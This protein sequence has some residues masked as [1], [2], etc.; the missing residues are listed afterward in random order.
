MQ[1]TDFLTPIDLEKQEDLSI[2]RLASMRAGYKLGDSP[3]PTANFIDLMNWT[4]ASFKVALKD[5]QNLNKF[6][7]NRIIIDGQFLQFCEESKITVDCLYKDSVISW[8]TDHGFEKF[9]VQGVFLIKSKDMEFLHAAL[10]HKGNQNE[11]EI[12][13]FVIVSEHNYKAYVNLRN[14]FDEWVQQR[15]RSNLHIRVIEGEDMPYTKDH[16]WADLFLPKEIKDQLQALVE[17]FLDSKEFYLK[18]RIPWKRGILLYG[19]PGN[20]KTSII[21]TVMS[22]YNFKPVTIVPGANDD[23]VREAF[24]YAEEQSPSLLYFED[25]DSLLEKSVDISSFLNLM[26]GISTKNG[27]LVI[28]TANDVKKLKSNITDRPSRFDRKF[29]IP[30]PNQEMAYI[31]L[32]RWFGNLLSTK[33]CKELSRY[34][35]KYDFSYAYLK[36]LYIS[37]MFEALSHNRKAPTEKDIENALNRLVKDKNI[38]NNG[39]TINTDKYFK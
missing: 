4:E 17:N 21:R 2:T 26:D 39:K 14:S 34:A 15:D 11:D 38:L 16:T 6:V 10:F 3:R 33:K 22:Q 19:K 20:G 18:N 8:K 5:Q 31:Y 27:L 32:K 13:F 37:S 7:H 23:A 9:F 35:E 24:S 36:E 25:L 30:L 1:K 29:E 28:A 12:S